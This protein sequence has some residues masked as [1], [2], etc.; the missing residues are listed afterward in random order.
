MITV[1]MGGIIYYNGCT[2]AEKRAYVPDGRVDETP[3]YASLFVEDDP[4][5]ADDWWKGY[6]KPHDLVWIENGKKYKAR[7]IEYRI[8]TRAEITFP[9]RANDKAKCVNLDNGLPHIDAIPKFV[10]DVI[11]PETI[12]EMPIRGGSLES[13]K[14]G[15]VAVV[16]WRLENNA[17]TV[18]IQA[19][20]IRDTKKLTLKNHKGP[21]G[22]EIVFSNTPD[23]FAL[24][25]H[26]GG[27]HFMLYD[28][29]NRNRPTHM[30]P[31][32]DQPL[33]P[34]LKDL[35]F[36]HSYLEY[37]AHRASGRHPIF[38]DAGCTPTCC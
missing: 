19:R 36:H 28:K 23:V 3:H 5:N 14:F 7:V 16:Q 33:P 10:L 9:H 1:H 32:P 8:P 25:Y 4:H 29:L 27:N 35:Q 31:M 26:P 17:R 6:K 2:V 22:L 21:L 20:T 30:P 15:K 34:N 37:L 18:T 12:A 13:R 24:G 38:P 11:N